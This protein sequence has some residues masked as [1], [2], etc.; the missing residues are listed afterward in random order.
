[1]PLPVLLWILVIA[2]SVSIGSILIAVLRNKGD[3]IGDELTQLT[4]LGGLVVV[5]AAPNLLWYKNVREVMMID[6][7]APREQ[8]VE[9]PAPATVE[10]PV[11]FHPELMVQ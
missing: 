10:A 8:S 6:L 4:I 9:K 3:V 2:A 1:M 5:L 11:I 7:P